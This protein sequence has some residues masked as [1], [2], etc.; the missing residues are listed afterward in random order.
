VRANLA[1][2]QASVERLDEPANRRLDSEFHLLW[3]GFFGNRE[4]IEV[5]QRLRDR[6]Y[7]IISRVNSLN[8]SRMTEGFKELVRVA[9]AM[10]AGDGDLAARSIEEHLKSGKLCL[11][12]PRRP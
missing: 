11:L 12:A 9:A 10:I 8:S 3:C 7:R 2:Q 5:M 4:I 6:I 1:A